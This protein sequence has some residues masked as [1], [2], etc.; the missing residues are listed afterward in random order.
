MAADQKMLSDAITTVVPGAMLRALE[1]SGDAAIEASS[2]LMHIKTRG[3]VDELDPDQLDYYEYAHGELGSL[4]ICDRVLEALRKG[5]AREMQRFVSGTEGSG[6]AAVL[7]GHIFERLA[8]AAVAA[9][10]EFRC[11][12]LSTGIELQKRLPP[13]VVRWFRDVTDIVAAPAGASPTVQWQPRSRSYC[14][15]DVVLAGGLLANATISSAHAIALSASR[16]GVPE[17][18]SQLFG[19]SSASI[20]FYWLVPESAYAL[21]TRPQRFTVSDM[22]RP[23]SGKRR[24]PADVAI[25]ISA[26]FPRAPSMHQ[27]ALLVPTALDLPSPPASDSR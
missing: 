6:E 25:A 23:V 15:V 5:N 7:R 13:A 20:E 12:D 21:F 8:L 19:S 26:R 11:R 27:Y 4:R 24:R 9:G 2:R 14:A 1:S 3:E 22:P 10:G 16:P 18:V 17:L